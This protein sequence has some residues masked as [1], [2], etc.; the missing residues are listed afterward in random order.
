[1]REREEREREGR[2]ERFQFTLRCNEL[3]HTPSQIQKEKGNNNRTTITRFVLFCRPILLFIF[4]IFLKR[5]KLRKGCNGSPPSQ[6]RGLACV[7]VHF[8]SLLQTWLLASV[9][10]GKSISYSFVLSPTPSY[11]RYSDI[12]IYTPNKHPNKH[13]NTSQCLNI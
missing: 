10:E 1:L 13:P 12:K 8:L 2:G 7:Y 3:H 4:L 6:G 5:Q 9:R 11:P